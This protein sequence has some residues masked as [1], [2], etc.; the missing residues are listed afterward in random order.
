MT[1]G[2]STII[3][4]NTKDVQALEGGNHICGLENTSRLRSWLGVASCRGEKGTGYV[5]HFQKGEKQSQS[6]LDCL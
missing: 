3:S 2:F 1:D 6:S 5:L 4:E